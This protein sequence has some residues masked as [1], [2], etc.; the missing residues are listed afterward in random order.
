M[1]SQNC[2]DHNFYNWNCAKIYY[3]I[4][5]DVRTIKLWPPLTNQRILHNCNVANK[6]TERIMKVLA[7]S[8]LLPNMQML[9]LWL[10]KIYSWP[11][12][13]RF[14]VFWRKHIRLLNTWVTGQYLKP[15]CNSG[16]CT[17]L[18]IEE[19]KQTV[20]AKR[21]ADMDAR[22]AWMKCLGE[23]TGHTGLFY[24]FDRQHGMQLGN[25]ISAHHFIGLFDY[26]RVHSIEIGPKAPDGSD[27]FISTNFSGQSS[28]RVD[29]RERQRGT[30]RVQN[31]RSV[32]LQYM[33]RA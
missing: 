5:C 32:C 1:Y 10:K 21:Q 29:E 8:A 19:R 23:T 2:Y 28:N 27:G 6:M 15:Y 7:S 12:M 4:C 26:H 18:R 30:Q 17:K 22:S 25:E 31:N 20:S 11:K 9:V 16:V 24:A 13:D 14:R 3:L 33:L